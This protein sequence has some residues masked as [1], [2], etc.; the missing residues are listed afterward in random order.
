M[1]TGGYF[2]GAERPGGEADHSPPSTAGGSG[3]AWSYTSTPQYVFMAW[4]L[5][6]HRD[7]FT[8]TIISM[9]LFIMG[10]WD[11]AREWENDDSQEGRNEIAVM[12]RRDFCSK[13]KSAQCG[14]CLTMD[15]FPVRGIVT[16]VSRKIVSELILKQNGSEGIDSG[17]LKNVI[18][19]EGVSKSFRTESITK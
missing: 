1:G 17:R 13:T 11:M 4:C 5:V 15:R 14:E 8:F 12:T 2:P 18:T 6:K 9:G 19:Y 3:N 16:N 10:N 7:N